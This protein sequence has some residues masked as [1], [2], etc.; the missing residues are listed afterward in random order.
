MKRFRALYG[1]T[2]DEPPAS[3]KWMAGVHEEDRPQVLGLLEQVLHTPTMDA[4]DNTFRIVRPDGTVSWMQS[5]GRADRDAAG[6]VTRLTGLELDITE[7]RRADEALQARRDEER[8]R[9]LRLLLETAT[10]G[11]VS[12]DAQ[13][14]IVTANHALEWMFG[15]DAG[16]LIGQSLERLVPPSLR[17]AH[18]QHRTQYFAAARPGPMGVDMDLVG[19]RQDGSTFPIEVILNHVATPGGGRA[20]AFVTDM[21]ARKRAEA[22]LRERTRE[23]EQRTAQLSRLASD[24]TLAEQHAREQ[25]A[26]TLHDGLQ[27]MLVSASAE[28]RTTGDA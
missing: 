7:R 8:D 4:W 27:Q 6:A 10:Q 22:V 16:E 11:I 25:L 9:E 14:T 18:V 23:L 12:V 28:R 21:T 5:L 1:F 20:L 13:G 24:L 3:E 26:K 15:W 2:P 17:D 19:Q